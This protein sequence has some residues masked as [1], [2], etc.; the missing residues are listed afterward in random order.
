MY[1]YI[2]MPPKGK[3]VIAIV[4]TNRFSVLASDSDSEDTPVEVKVEEKVEPPFRKWITEE[5]SRFKSD[6]T[7]IFSSPF[8]KGMRSKQWG[9]R[10]KEDT[11][12]WI[13][14]RWNEPQFQDTGSDE[15]R[16]DVIYEPREDSITVEP[17]PTIVMKDSIT[18]QET[19]TA[20]A[21]AEKIKKSLETAES[22]RSHKTEYKE[23][24]GKLSFFRKT[25]N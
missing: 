17:K 12:G 20:I 22:A 23:A 8:Y 5:D 13:S 21:W 1:T 24:L 25:S 6:T 3:A 16:A 18:T 14:I 7:N 2:S 10:T 9:K 4:P 11:D 19:L 15:E